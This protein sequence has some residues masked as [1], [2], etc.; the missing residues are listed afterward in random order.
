MQAAVSDRAGKQRRCGRTRSPIGRINRRDTAQT[1]IG[2][3]ISASLGFEP[4]QRDSESLVLPLHYEATREKIKDRQPLLQVE[5]SRV[6]RDLNGWGFR[7][8]QDLSAFSSSFDFQRLSALCH[9]RARVFHHFIN[10]FV[11]M[12]WIVMKEQ[13]LAYV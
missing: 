9:Q 8:E 5:H 1:P 11:I 13:K 3:N 2:K 10:H 7:A 6:E 12:I 4:R